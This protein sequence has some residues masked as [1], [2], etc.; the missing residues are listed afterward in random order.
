V[1]PRADLGSG[2]PS[3][4]VDAAPWVTSFDV[5]GR[6]GELALGNLR[7]RD[8]TLRLMGQLTQATAATPAELMEF[9]EQVELFGLGI[10]YMDAQLLAATRLT[11]D[12]QF[13]TLDWRL[14]AAAERL[15]VA[16]P[17]DSKN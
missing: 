16:Y 13:W 4:K 9:I 2:V 14:R 5:R 6:A 7:R 10:G 17:A 3:P 15:G 8:K 12:A 1:S 11:A